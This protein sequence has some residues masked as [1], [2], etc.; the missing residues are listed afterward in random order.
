MQTTKENYLAIPLHAY[1]HSFS[2]CYVGLASKIFPLT[3]EEDFL[4]VPLDVTDFASHT[5]CAAAAVNH[6]GKV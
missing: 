3:F 5:D 2:F 6:F 4:V 1:N